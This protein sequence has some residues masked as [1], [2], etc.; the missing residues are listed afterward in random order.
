MSRK[1]IFSQTGYNLFIL[2]D[3]SLTS[4][5]ENLRASTALYDHLA[6]AETTSSTASKF[7]PWS[8]AMGYDG[9]LWDFYQK[10]DPARGERFGVAM[11]G[12]SSLSKFD[13]MLHGR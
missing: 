3:C 11:I 8:R 5:D 6:D 4:S 10:V 1:D 13:S 2:T 7:A 9:N 12:F